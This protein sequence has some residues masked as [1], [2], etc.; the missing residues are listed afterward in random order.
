MKIGI[1]S[2][3][4]AAVAF[5]N[6]AKIV[7]IARKVRKI[8]LA[9]FPKRRMSQSATRLTRSVF[10]MALAMMKADTFSQMTGS[11]KVAIAGFAFRMP[12]STRPQMRSIEVR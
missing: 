1:M 7:L 5:T 3:A 12:V 6:A 2:A 10:T 11:P 8:E 9:F 4:L